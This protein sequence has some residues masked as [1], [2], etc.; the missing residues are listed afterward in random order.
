MK[1]LY[2]EAER[3]NLPKVQ[4][5]IDGMLDEAGCPP[6]TRT[7]ID[8]AVEEIFV[9]IACYAYHPDSGM[10]LIQVSLLESPPSVEITFADQGRPYNP[11]EKPDP[12]LTLPIRQRKKGGLGIDKL[13]WPTL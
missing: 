6:L 4:E 10:V 9:N 2:I 5:L 7:A 1:E 3:T 8:V 12:D 11:L 13:P